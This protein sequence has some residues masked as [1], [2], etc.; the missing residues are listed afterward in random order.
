M[1]LAE[2]TAV[3]DVGVIVGAAEGGDENPAWALLPDLSPRDLELVVVAPPEA[4]PDA[5]V[6][7]T[8]TVTNHEAYDVWAILCLVW[9]PHASVDPAANQGWQQ[10]EDILYG[11]PWCTDVFVRSGESWTKTLVIEKPVGSSV[12]EV[13]V[14]RFANAPLIAVELPE[15]RIVDPGP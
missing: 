14:L 3:S 7:Y 13:A 10:S 5:Q 1:V 4:D 2:A 15:V 12:L 8:A 9:L 6:P 11:V